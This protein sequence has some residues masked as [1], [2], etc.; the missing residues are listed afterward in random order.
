MTRPLA[1]EVRVSPAAL[2]ALA[3]FPGRLQA[4]WAALFDR[5]QAIARRTAPVDLGAHRASIT[6]EVHATASPMT[7]SL[8]A[9]MVYSR[10]LELGFPPVTIRPVRAQALH[11]VVGGQDVFTRVVHL[12]ARPGRP[13]LQ[14]ALEA[15]VDWFVRETEADVARVGSG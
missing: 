4:R 10:G 3:A 1:I 6:T 8:G 14:P 9:G 2:E 12:P 5:A 15:A 11:F 7:G 13:H